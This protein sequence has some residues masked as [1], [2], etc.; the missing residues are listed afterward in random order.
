MT[1][2]SPGCGSLRPSVPKYV[3]RG[4]EQASGE[5]KAGTPGQPDTSSPLAAL[6]SR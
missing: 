3:R 1:S 4:C 6:L 2:G 5:G